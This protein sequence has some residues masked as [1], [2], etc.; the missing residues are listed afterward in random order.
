MATYRSIAATETDPQAPVTAAL[1]KAL[2]AN[3]TAIAEG[4]PGAPVL[5][6]SWFPYD[7]FDV[8]DGATGLVYDFAVDGGVGGASPFVFPDFVA[9][10]DYRFVF[11]GIGIAAS[12]ARSLTLSLYQETAAAWGPTFSI[13]QTANS[14]SRFSSMVEIV[15]PMGGRRAVYIGIITVDS[16]S[17]GIITASSDIKRAEIATPQRRL[18]CRMA[19][20]GTENTNAG[21]VYMFR[22]RNF[23]FG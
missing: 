3:P 17:T 9:G 21:S 7:M 6:S 13:L 12:T 14:S 10:Y 20:T 4:A 1:M 15:N 2:D 19:C 8:G 5:T 18:R 16:A 22:R 11:E 23:M